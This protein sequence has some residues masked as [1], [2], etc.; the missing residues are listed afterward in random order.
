[1]DKSKRRQKIFPAR[2]PGER[3]RQAWDGAAC[4]LTST[5]IGPTFPTPSRNTAYPWEGCACA[6]DSCAR[7]GV[8]RDHELAGFQLVP[9]PFG[10]WQ[11][12][13]NGGGTD[14]TC[15]DG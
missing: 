2:R 1:M 15:F 7:R 3:V 8:R 9:R 12:T 10:T 14:K 13:G 5:L 4:F 6:A 11:D